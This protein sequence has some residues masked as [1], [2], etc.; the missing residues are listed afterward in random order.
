MLAPLIYIGGMQEMTPTPPSR[1]HYGNQGHPPTPAVTPLPPSSPS[2]RH[3]SAQIPFPV[4]AS[5][6]GA[7]PSGQTPAYGISQQQTAPQI[8]MAPLPPNIDLDPDAESEKIALPADRWKRLN[9]VVA[10]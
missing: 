4:P 5:M 3:G 2:W 8:A 10:V 6:P 9:R 1:G 7:T